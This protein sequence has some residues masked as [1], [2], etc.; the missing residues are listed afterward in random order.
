M[1]G[2]LVCPESGRKFPISKGV[3]S[4]VPFINALDTSILPSLHPQRMPQP[5]TVR[6]MTPSNSGVF[7]MASC[8]LTPDHP[9]LHLRC[10]ALPVFGSQPA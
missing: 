3:A 5:F 10:G 4:H 2:N 1:E 9:T 7:G 6:L 8:T